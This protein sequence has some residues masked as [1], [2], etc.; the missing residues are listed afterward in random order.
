MTST[1]VLYLSSHQMTAYSGHAGNLTN[2]GSFATT[3]SGHQEFS[4]YLAKHPRS[5]FTILANVSEEGFQIETIPFL[6]GSDRRAII[7]RKL[8]QF[9]FT[10]ALTASLSL[11]YQKTQRKDERVML[12]ALTSNDFFAPWLNAISYAGVA[13]AGIYSLPLLAPALLKKLHINDEQCLLLTVQ[14]Q[15]IRQSYFEKGELHF[16]RLTPLQNS[17]I[18]GIA[19][20]FWAETLKL[21]QY[22]A[23]QRL[24]GRN[25]LIT[26]HILAHPGALKAIETSCVDTATTR[27]NILNI[28]DVAKRIGLKTPPPDTHCEQLFLNLLLTS[29]PRIQ[30]ADDELRHDYHLRQIRSALHVLGGLALLG[31]LLFAGS[32]LLETYRLNQESAELRS[33]SGLARLRYNDIVK[34]FPA[35][36]TDNETLRRIIDRYTELEKNG[37]SPTGLYHE[38]SR[39]LQ[40]APAAELDS[41]DWNVGGFQ[42][43]AGQNASGIAVAKD[44]ETAIVHGNLKLAANANARQMLAAFNVLVEALK[45]N[46]KLQVDVLQRPFDIES[47][48]ALKGGDTTLEDDKPRSFALQISRKLES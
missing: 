3:G 26:A 8:G 5:V 35:I 28:E 27:Y 23:S 25:Q 20:T 6:T 39:A 41:I 15:S 40:A 16:S 10:A 7:T 18:G 29:P 46:S 24:I 9:F 12:A 2:E 30:F 48:K 47:G 37:A 1:R 14:D 22:L 36:P 17:S 19:Q 34:T 4:A 44:S 13:L 32:S 42:P 45:A 38:I 31:G 11:G 21:Q 43:T 33:E